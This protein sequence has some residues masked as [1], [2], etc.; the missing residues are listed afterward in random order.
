MTIASMWFIID[1]AVCFRV[2]GKDSRRYLHNRLSQDIRSLQPG[3]SALAAAL[4]AQGRVEGLFIVA[5]ESDD[6]FL[7]ASDGGDALALSQ[8]LMR[9]KVADRV[10]CSDVSNEIALVHLAI[11]GVQART[12]AHSA[13]L[14]VGACLQRARIALAGVDLIFTGINA[15]RAGEAVMPTL[16]APLR[17]F[18]YDLLRWRAVCATFPEE[19]NEQGMLLEYGLRQAVSFTKGCYIGQEVVERS[20]AIGR[21]PRQLERIQLNG[22]ELVGK[23]SPIVTPSGESLGK[24]I[25]E[26]K[27]DHDGS[28]YLFALLSVGKYKRGDDVQCAQR[29]GK[30]VE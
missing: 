7:V 17:R 27:N 21:V 5:C 20:D 9:F 8:A 14:G 25:G 15:E 18:E 30:I 29:H 2:S 26:I 28:L 11:D 1:T 4:T 6:S 3:Q 22:R 23:G 12:L 16:G 24:V 19:I 10:V 13:G